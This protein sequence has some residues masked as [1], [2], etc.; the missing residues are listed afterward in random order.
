MRFSTPLRYELEGW[1]ESSAAI[2]AMGLALATVGIVQTITSPAAQPIVALELFVSFLVPTGLATGGYWLASRN[3]SPDVRFRVTTWVSIGIVAAC[4]L[5]GWLLVYVSLEGGTIH[6]PLSLVTTLAAVGGATGFVAAVHASPRILPTDSTGAVESARETTGERESAR[7][8]AERTSASEATADLEDETVLEPTA[9]A[10]ASALAVTVPEPATDRP[11][12]SCEAATSLEATA[13][14]E[15][16]V[17]DETDPLAPSPGDLEP[18]V[19][20]VAA[21]PETTEAVLE[22]L[23]DERARIVLAHL[24]HDADGT[25]SL[26]DL[27]RVVAAHTDQPAATAVASLRHA[28]LPLLDAV[29]AIDWDPHADRVSAPEHAVFEEGVRDASALLESFEPG[30][31]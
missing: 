24:Y 8:D 23:R 22:V 4:G 12:A 2:V 25:Q 19:E 5:G 28:T 11:V 6:E 31:R 16:I 7:D 20:R 10:S 15:P 30:T 18:S 21:V 17:P 26:D 13:P 3:V 1:G 14:S 29:R 9:G 27:A